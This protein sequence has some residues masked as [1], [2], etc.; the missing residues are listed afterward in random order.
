MFPPA[1]VGITARYINIKTGEVEWSASHRVGGVK[2]WFWWI[3]G[4]PFI[5]AVA[6]ILSPTA[7]DQVSNATRAISR[8]VQTQ[9]ETRGR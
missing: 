7:E 3:L 1:K 8:T 6:T 4:T 9:L 5:G 2:R